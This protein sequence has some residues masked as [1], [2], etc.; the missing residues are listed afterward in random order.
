[1][2]NLIDSQ[3]RVVAERHARE[4]IV[5]L[6][7]VSIPLLK[8]LLT[9][10]KSYL[11]LSGGLGSSQYIQDRI[12]SRYEKGLHSGV[13]P[14]KVLLAEEPYV[15]YSIWQYSVILTFNR[16][17]SVVHG[18]VM[19]RVQANRGGPDMYSCVNVIVFLEV[20]ADSDPAD[21]AV[22]H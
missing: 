9:P 12:K 4:T 3:I 15:F 10:L 6:A 11:V 8:S 1:M 16:Q 14:I 18:L 21:F 20:D 13:D 17:L 22:V 2:F 5:R 19:A 7:H